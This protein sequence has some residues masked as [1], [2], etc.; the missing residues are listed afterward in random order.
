MATPKN[1]W[2]EWKFALVGTVGGYK[3]AFSVGVLLTLHA[4]ELPLRF[5][6]GSSGTALAFAEYVASGLRAAGLVRTFREIESI[7][8]KALFRQLHMLRDN[9]LDWLEDQHPIWRKIV[10]AAWQ[11]CEAVFH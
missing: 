5:I 8:P 6:L 4:A 2:S 7:G 3:V 10:N 9:L 11:F 1:D